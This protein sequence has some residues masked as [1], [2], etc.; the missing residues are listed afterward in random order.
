MPLHV[1]VSALPGLAGT[2]TGDEVVC[3][4]DTGIIYYVSPILNAVNYVWDITG[5]GVITTGNGTNSIRARFPTGPSNCAVTVYGSNSCGAGLISPAKY[6]TVN[7]LPPVP[8]ITQNGPE[9]VSSAPAGNQWYFN[10]TLIPGADQATYTPVLSGVYTVIVTLSGCSSSASDGFYFIMTA[11]AKPQPFTV[12]V[13]PVPNDGKFRVFLNS[14]ESER[15]NLSV[16]NALGQTIWEITGIELN[17]DKQQ[18]I[19]LRPVPPG[20]YTLVIEGES[21]RVVRKVVVE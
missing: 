4:G 19:D 18:T 12:K 21:L 8:V 2:P 20:V 3:Q 7:L 10:G 13:Y 16:L 5:G 9:L 1:N 15:V 11:I 17:G 6:V 14:G